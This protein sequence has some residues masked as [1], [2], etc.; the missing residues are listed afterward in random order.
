MENTIYLDAGNV[1]TFV[2]PLASSYAYKDGLRK[3]L[4]GLYQAACHSDNRYFVLEGE[5]VRAA[6]S[7]ETG[8]ASYMQDGRVLVHVDIPSVTTD[9]IEQARRLWAHFP[10]RK[11][12]VALKHGE[13]MQIVLKPTAHYAGKLAREGWTV[14]ELH[15]A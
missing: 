9:Q 6:Q 11:C 12:F 14:R 13:E 4:D 15:R 7:T 3:V 10:Y 5:T 1:G 8:A 2:G